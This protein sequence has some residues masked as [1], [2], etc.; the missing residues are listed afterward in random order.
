MGFPTFKGDRR[1]S[2]VGLNLTRLGR[3]WLSVKALQAELRSEWKT[4]LFVF[5]TSPLFTCFVLYLLSPFLAFVHQLIHWYTY[6]A[7]FRQWRAS[8]FL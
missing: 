6:A 3:Y 5:V 4:L 7:F 2:L 8:Q 1:R